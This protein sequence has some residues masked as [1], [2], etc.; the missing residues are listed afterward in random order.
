MLVV[1]WLIVRAI[2]VL[3][4][5]AAIALYIRGTFRDRVEYRVQNLPDP[6]SPRFPLVVASLSNAPI[7]SGQ[8]TGIQSTPDRIQATRLETIQS[9]KRT[10]HFETFF[11]TP[12]QRADRFADALG[13]RARAG[14]AVQC[15]VDSYGSRTLPSSYWNRLRSAGV[16]VRWFN[17]FNW[18]APASYGGRTHRKLLIV[19]GKTALIGG[20]GIS[21]LWD[22]SAKVGDTQPWFD[23]EF[24][25]EGAVVATLEGIFMQHWMY[26][27]GLADFSRVA[28]PEARPS[29]RPI[30]VTPGDV[31]NYRSSP[32]RALFQTCILAATQRI[33]LA[34]PYFLPDRA[35]R[36]FFIAAKQQGIDV[37]ILTTSSRSDKRFV[38]YASRELYNDLLSGNVEIY[39]YQPSMIH[40]KLLLIDECWASAGS[41]N[42]D[43]RSFFHNDELNFSTGDRQFVRQVEQLFQQAF[44][45]SRR[46]DRIEW[47]QRPWQ[48]R[49]IGRLAGFFQWEL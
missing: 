29:D 3:V 5:L 47:E 43:P 34:S 21:D 25:L 9:A 45:R 17:R 20:A 38:Y 48:Q 31:P 18:K 26:A 44:A 30:V 1:L 28:L 33:W 6:A 35:S 7:A 19:D 46:V 41:A 14:V 24:R 23:C 10:L 40:A 12:G 37:R 32:I 39:E 22:G 16:D 42:F 27:G 15:L 4:L 36:Q 8:I 13:D 11:M 49:I 2:L